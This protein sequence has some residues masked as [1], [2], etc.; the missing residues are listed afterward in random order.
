MKKR[1]TKTTILK[2]GWVI[3]ALVGVLAGISK[4]D[5]MI[6]KDYSEISTYVS[7]DDAW[8]ITI[9]D[10]TYQNVTLT[11]LRFQPVSKGTKITMQRMLPDDFGLEEGAMRFYVR[12]CSARMFIDGVQVYD[13]GS[14]RLAEG[15]TLGSGI[16]YINFP[17]EYEGK[18]LR[19]ELVM[20]EDE[21]LAKLDSIKL[22]EWKNAYRARITEAR[23]PLFCGIFLSLFGLIFCVITIFA[24]IFSIKYVRLFC[25]S[26]FA[27]CMGLWT[28]SYYNVLQIFAVPLYTISVINYV[29][30]F[31]APIPL[32]VYMHDPV[33]KLNSRPIKIFYQ[34]FFAIATAFAF[35]TILLHML[36][37]I[38]L[39]GVL[40]YMQMILLAGLLFFLLVLVLNLKFSNFENRLSVFGLLFIFICVAYDILGYNISRYLG[41]TNLNVNAVSSIGIMVY[42][43][44]LFITFYIEMTK[45]MMEQKERDFLIRS[46]YT[47]ELTQIHNR[48]YCMEYM[49]K[50]KEERDFKYTVICFD[51]N[52]LKTVNDTCGHAK[53][54]LL[55]KS[56]AEVIAETFE[57]HGFVS[58]TGGDEFVSVIRISDENEVLALMKQFQDNIDKKNL[59]VKDLDMSI[60]WGYASGS[61][62]DN[63]IDK[64]YQLADD[65]MYMKKREMKGII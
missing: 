9:N 3:L 25:I 37:I 23:L 47:D 8:D 27:I 42:I 17:R 54:D 24:L 53:G 56:A 28:L 29:T 65:R 19:I 48:R 55:I 39:A 4:V 51:L 1:F 15:R 58:R 16:Q 32:T 33:E 22:C 21:V 34:F 31:L 36:Q 43:C 60:A 18:T 11:E 59:A 6:A 57:S 20:A 64:V 62:S 12:H 14:D 10:D 52:N 38:H 26:I 61:Q 5:G 40:K 46:A 7:L 44:I 63:D 41:I 2:F 13:Y 49:N 45:K 50:L 35:I 30:L